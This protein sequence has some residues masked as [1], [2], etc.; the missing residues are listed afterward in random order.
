VLYFEDN[1]VDFNARENKFICY[2]SHLRLVCWINVGRYVAECCHEGLTCTASADI[3]KKILCA[4]PSQPENI[5]PY[6]RVY[7]VVTNQVVR[8]NAIFSAYTFNETQ[9]QY[10][11]APFDYFA[12]TIDTTFCVCMEDCE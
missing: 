6:A 7:P 10:L 2:T 5:T 8:S 1:G 12:L 3:I 4:L 11:M 9:V